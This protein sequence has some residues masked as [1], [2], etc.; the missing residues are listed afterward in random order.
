M[1]A[2]NEGF[3][4][5]ITCERGGLLAAALGGGGEEVAACLARQCA[6][7][8]RSLCILWTTRKSMCFASK[9]VACSS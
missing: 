6:L 8:C 4:I 1:F 7:R 2:V 5:C 3:R 9:S